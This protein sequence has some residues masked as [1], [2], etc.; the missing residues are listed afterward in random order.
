[1]ENQAKI[2]PASTNEFSDSTAN[3]GQKILSSG[4]QIENIE[5]KAGLEQVTPV[6]NPAQEVVMSDAAIENIRSETTTTV[7]SEVEA[8]ANK[9]SKKQDNWWAFGLKM[10]VLAVVVFLFTQFVIPPYVVKGQS[11]EP[12]FHTGERILT[13]RAVFKLFSQP[14]RDDVVILSEPDTGEVLI[15]RVIGLPGDTVQVTNSTVFINGQPLNEPFIKF[16]TDYIFGPEV[17]PADNYFVMGDNRSSS[18]DSH[19]FG[20]VPS[21]KII[22]RVM[23]TL[24]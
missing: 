12:N 23:L 2:L 10:A 6:E 1:M 19:I 3:A 5:S 24:F 21:D 16:K 17:V 4:S 7:P 13:D 8:N 9:S 20:F 18:L 11:M 22:A 15:K 14:H